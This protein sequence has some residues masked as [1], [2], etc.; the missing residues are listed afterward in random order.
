MTN[1]QETPMPGEPYRPSNGLE[2]AC[3][4]AEWCGRCQ[5][6]A[7]FQADPEHNDGCEIAANTMCFDI[8]DP[9]YPK[10]WIYGDDGQPKCTAFEEPNHG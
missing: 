9:Q 3:F 10:E 2:G 6:D 5:R 8:D 7:A 4:M 1:P